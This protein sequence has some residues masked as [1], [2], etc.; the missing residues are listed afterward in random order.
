MSNL[1][2][3]IKDDVIATMKGGD[4]KRLSVLRLISA[5]LKQVEVDKRI[6][7]DQSGVEDILT[8]MA[9]QRRESI[10]AFGGR[11]DLIDQEQYE[12]DVIL[13]YLPQA[14]SEAEVEQFIQAAM[15][16]TG[17]SKM[18]DMGKV[19]AILKPQLANRADL[20]QVSAK[21]KQLLT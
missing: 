7:L 21:V 5:A 19:M 20:S 14:M 18:A 17:A 16:E 6:E 10:Q 12:L 1:K 8:K 3:R 2:Q 13:S 9:K 11:Q 4:K 15:T